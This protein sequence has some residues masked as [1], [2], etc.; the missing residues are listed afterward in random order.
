MRLLSGLATLLAIAAAVA[1]AGCGGGGETRALRLADAAGAS[2]GEAG[3]SVELPPVGTP[4]RRRTG[5]S[6]TR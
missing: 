3:V 4:E 5:T 6:S 1:S 2:T